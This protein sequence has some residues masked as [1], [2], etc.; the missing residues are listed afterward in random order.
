MFSGGFDLS[1]AVG[2]DHPSAANRDIGTA[3]KAAV[4]L[5]ATAARSGQVNRPGRRLDRARLLPGR[6]QPHRRRALGRRQRSP[7]RRHRQRVR[8]YRKRQRELDIEP[9]LRRLGG[10]AE[11]FG[12]ATRL[13]GAAKLAVAR[14]HRR[15]S[16]LEHADAPAGRLRIP[17]GQGRQRLP[18]EG[19]RS[20][21]R[22]RVRRR[23][24]RL[25]LWRERRRFR[26]RPRE[27][28]DLRGV[29]RGA[30]GAVAEVWIAALARGK[31]QLLGAFRRDRPTDAR[32]WARMGDELLDRHPLRPRS[33]L[34]GHPKPLLDTRDRFRRQSLRQ[35]ER[36][37]RAVVRRE[38]QS[39]HRLHDR[40]A[41][42][43]HRD[44]HDARH[45]R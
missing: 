1:I 14:F 23:G 37:R 19:R 40:P 28:D 3:S 6:S 31:T 41:A 22:Q 33:D 36:R 35:S 9:R 10:E 34:R 21:A 44:E 13:V 17:V 38:R 42:D 4:T 16:R 12:V 39:G 20:R 25:L 30:P 15:R 5:T 45:I 26:V 8:R 11:R 18:A 29:R 43:D 32:R 2:P 24:I 7:G 27:L